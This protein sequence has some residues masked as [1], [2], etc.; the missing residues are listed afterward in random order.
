MNKKGT[1][2]IGQKH[3]RGIAG[4]KSSNCVGF[5]NI[6]VTSGSFNKIGGVEAKTL[7]PFKVGPVIDKNGL[8]A[9]LFENYWQGGKLWPKAGHIKEGTGNMP[10]DKWFQFREKV[11][12][13]KKGK[14][15]PLPLKQYGFPT[16]AY[17]NDI[18]YGY[19]DSRKDIYIPIYYELIKNLPVIQEMKKLLDNGVN[20]MIIDGDGPPKNIYPE[21]LEITQENWNLMVE[22]TTYPFGHG[23]VVAGLL[24]GLL[25]D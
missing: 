18:P 12:S 2:R 14:R 24:S 25:N 22:D 17:Y 20:I 9:E 21:G 15:R 10:S 4:D 11:Y 16:C 13:M 3:R 7:S 19:I 6:D 8:Q 1:V 5:K 23:Y